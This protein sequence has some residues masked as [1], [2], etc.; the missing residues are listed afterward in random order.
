MVLGSSAKCLQTL[1]RVWVRK[2]IYMTK[3]FDSKSFYK[4]NFFY[5][6]KVMTCSLHISSENYK[7]IEKIS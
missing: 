1:L 2:Y 3:K 5:I 7:F 6:F 4:K